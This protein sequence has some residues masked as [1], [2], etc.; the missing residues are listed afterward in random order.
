MLPRIEPL[1][2]VFFLTVAGDLAVE[3]DIAPLQGDLLAVDIRGG[4]V[5]IVTAD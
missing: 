4:E 3:G 2:I 5:L 1:V